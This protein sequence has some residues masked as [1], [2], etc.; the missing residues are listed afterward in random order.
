[1]P[2]VCAG[3]GCDKKRQVQLI[4]SPF[5]EGCAMKSSVWIQQWARDTQV[6]TS[7]RLDNRIL[8]DANA[9]F[10]QS[11]ERKPTASKL[12]SS[13]RRIIMKSPITKLLGR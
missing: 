7:E 6:K 13:L 9:A 11:T 3:K 4:G 2:T 1:M 12:A 10:A 5:V 8:A